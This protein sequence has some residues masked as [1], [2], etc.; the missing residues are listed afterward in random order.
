MSHYTT[1]EQR[2]KAF[3][4]DEMR[5]SNNSNNELI[6]H[7][8][9]DA[10]I[11][12]K[13]IAYLIDLWVSVF[14]LPILYNI[15]HY[16]KWWQ[17]L[18]QQI[19][20]IRIYR[21]HNVGQIA[22]IPQLL[23]RFAIKLWF[24]ISW[25]IVG[26]NLAAMRFNGYPYGNAV[27]ISYGMLYV[28][29]MIIWIHGYTMTMISNKHRRWLQDLWSGTIVAYDHG[30]NIKRTIMG[31]IICIVLYYVIFW[32]GPELIS[33]IDVYTHG[34][35]EAWYWA[36]WSWMDRWVLTGLTQLHKITP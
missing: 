26:M 3:V 6:E 19:V 22:S 34:Q 11:L 28:S 14:I 33:W 16:L 30:H 15:Y 7:K 4:P 8:H 20:G 36:A 9:D 27:E 21:H 24:L 2:F 25:A 17:T 29:M 32:L 18:W 12:V 13:S 35:W 23:V 31:L 10:G 1:F 5:V